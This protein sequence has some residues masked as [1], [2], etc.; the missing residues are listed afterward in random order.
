MLGQPS[1]TLAGLHCH[2]GSNVFAAD[3]FGRAAEVMAAFA[4]PYDLPELVLG[5]GSGRALRRTGARHRRPS[6]DGVNVSSESR[7]CP[8]RGSGASGGST[9]PAHAAR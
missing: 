5:G 7:A 4:A 2:I 6:H 3:S 8:L 9:S 1:L